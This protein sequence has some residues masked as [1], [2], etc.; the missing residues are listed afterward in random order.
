MI[1]SAQQQ[2]NTHTN[3]QPAL[4]VF[5]EIPFIFQ[6]VYFTVLLFQIVFNSLDIFRFFLTM[7][8]FLN[9]PRNYINS[10]PFLDCK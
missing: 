8:H 7:F 1:Y 9:F 5:H 4:H 2:I 10:K 6:N 3:R